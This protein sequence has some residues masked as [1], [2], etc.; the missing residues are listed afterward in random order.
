MDRRTSQ[1]CAVIVQSKHPNSIQYCTRVIICN[2]MLSKPSAPLPS[3][4]RVSV[5]ATPPAKQCAL[6]DASVLE[7]RQEGPKGCRRRYS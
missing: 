5:S 2:S 7:A 4:Q 1:L 6:E 3:I